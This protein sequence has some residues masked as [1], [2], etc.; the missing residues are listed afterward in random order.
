MIRK[1]LQSNFE[2]LGY[3]TKEVLAIEKSFAE[4]EEVH[5]NRQGGL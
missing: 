4:W 2:G 3:L 5:K 1:L